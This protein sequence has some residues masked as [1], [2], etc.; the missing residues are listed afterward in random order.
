MIRRAGDQGRGPAERAKSEENLRE[1]LQ[2]C[3]LRVQNSAWRRV[4]S[5]GYSAICTEEGL[6]PTLQYVL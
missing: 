2:S 6:I 1:R 3:A 5:P 4:T